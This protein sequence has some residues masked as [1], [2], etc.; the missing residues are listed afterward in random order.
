MKTLLLILLATSMQ[1]QSPARKVLNNG[2]IVLTVGVGAYAMFGT[3]KA[4]ASGVVP[5]TGATLAFLGVGA[6]SL[7]LNVES[8]TR[9]HPESLNLPRFKD[10][11]P[12]MLFAFGGGV[13]NGYNHVTLMRADVF[14]EY[15]KWANPEWV[16]FT[17]SW[18]NKKSW[19][20]GTYGDDMFHFT[21]QT[22]T[23]LNSFAGAWLPKGGRIWKALAL[24]GAHWVGQNAV[25][26]IYRR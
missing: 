6:T 9:K 5:P 11:V 10:M 20:P 18:K 26:Y 23:W 21:S 16:D 24:T 19:I 3:N 4:F 1:A 12:S 8:Y 2:S 14:L 22:E 15:H 7:L 25:L 17:L 13:F